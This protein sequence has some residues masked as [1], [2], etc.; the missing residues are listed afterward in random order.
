MIPFVF[1]TKTFNSYKLHE[2]LISLLKE[3]CP[4]EI[5]AQIKSLVVFDGLKKIF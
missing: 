1:N 2:R 4:S 3:V 5:Y